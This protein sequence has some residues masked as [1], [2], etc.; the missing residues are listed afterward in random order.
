MKKIFPAFLKSIR[1]LPFRKTVYS[2]QYVNIR[3]NK[4]SSKDINL[5]GRSMVEMLGV[6][7]IVGVLSIGGIAGYVTA[8]R[9]L[10]INNLKDEISTIV[11]NIRSMYFS[12]KDYTGINEITLINAGLIPDWMVGED[13]I[14]IINKA[15]GSVYIESAAAGTKEAGSFILVF[16]DLDAYTCRELAI[17][18]WGSDMASG[19]LGMTIKNDG[20]LTVDT[21][22]L[23]AAEIQSGNTTILAR[24]LASG[25]L[26]QV[27]ELCNCGS[28]NLC[29]IAWKFQ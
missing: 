16:N 14:S 9:N 28:M 3:Q 22:N 4:K 12:A 27:Y 25:T 23:T 24:D 26:N 6:L 8:S 20:D 18:D 1:F 10:R 19:F 15:K 2:P 13:N 17:S 5:S 29:A 7:A 11:A 21:S